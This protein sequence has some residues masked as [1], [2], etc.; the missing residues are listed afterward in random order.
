[1]KM[2]EAMA[3]IDSDDH[4]PGFMVSFERAGDGFLRGDYF[5]DKHAG[6][7]LIP[8]EEEAWEIARKFASKTYG[9]CVHIYVVDSTF[10]PVKDYK[11][12]YIVNRIEP[13]RG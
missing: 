11:D 9:R 12:K 6:E 5:P 1:M 2:A 3:I 10:S 8:T 7:P 13:G 4:K